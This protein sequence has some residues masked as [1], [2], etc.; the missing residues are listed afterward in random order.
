MN[1]HPMPFFLN[2]TPTFEKDFTCFNASP[3]EMMENASYFILK[4]LF[5]FKIFNIV[6][7]S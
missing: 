5:V 7:I 2:P 1:A 6:F 3:L 4:T